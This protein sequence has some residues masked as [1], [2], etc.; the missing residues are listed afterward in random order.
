MKLL[1]TLLFIP[2]ILFAETKTVGYE[3]YIPKTETTII[4]ESNLM[5]GLVEDKERYKK[6][7]RSTI[8]TTLDN[9]VKDGKVNKVIVNQTTD[10]RGVITATFEQKEGIVPI[11]Y[12][13]STEEENKKRIQEEIN[14]LKAIQDSVLEEQAKTNL[15]L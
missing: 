11:D 3:Y 6:I 10:R 15:G 4:Q 12:N 2:S 9:Y 1:I 8:S 14:R 5:T 7:R 13:Y